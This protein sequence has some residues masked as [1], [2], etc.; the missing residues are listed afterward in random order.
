MKMANEA[1]IRI[2]SECSNSPVTQIPVDYMPAGSGNWFVIPSGS[3]AGKKMFYYD[4]QVGKGKPEKTILFVHGNPESSYTYSKIRQEIEQHSKQT[5]RII[6]MDHIGFGLSDQASFEMVDM[7][8]AA[9]LKQLIEH[10]NLN[11]ITLVIHDWGGAIGVGALIDSPNRV[12]AIILM[13]TTIFPFPK[14]GLTYKNFPFSWLAWNHLGFYIPAKIWQFI[15]PMVMFSPAG[16]L[17]FLKHIVG[18]IGRIFTGKL[19]GS[20]TLYRQMFSTKMNALSS[21]RCVKQTRVWGHGY[22]YKEKTLGKQSNV[23]FYRNMQNILPKAWGA[24]AAKQGIPC[25]AYFGEFDPIARPEVEKQWLTALPQ[26]NGKITRFKNVGHF[27]EE[28]K[29]EDIA[30]GILSV[31]N[32]Y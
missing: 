9:N 27:V 7:H 30:Q 29:Y 23:M 17:K 20:E 21:K 1:Q 5:V 19:T 12:G 31:L 26:L 16:K 18:F 11:N 24:S 13:N 25:R 28:H 22:Q 6:A 3:D 4:F 2:N 8:H 10:L 15:P 32:E 14:T